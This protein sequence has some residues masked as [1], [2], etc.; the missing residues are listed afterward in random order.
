M[1]RYYKRVVKDYDC[2]CKGKTRYD[3]S[4]KKIRETIQKT[5]CRRNNSKLRKEIVVTNLLELYLLTTIYTSMVYSRPATLF[6]HP[7]M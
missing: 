1:K 3:P 7:R 2:D 4:V 6:Q 5:M